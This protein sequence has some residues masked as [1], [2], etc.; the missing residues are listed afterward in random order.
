MHLKKLAVCACAGSLALAVACSKQQSQS[1]V[2]PS[3]TVNPGT[4]AAA[5]GSTLKVTAPTPVSPV[6]NAQPDGGLVLTATKS[7]GKFADIPLSYEFEVFN[8]SNQR[9]YTSGVTGGDGNGNNV[10]HS[11]SGSLEFDQPYTWRVRG[12]FQGAS[13][14]WSSSA[15]FRAP[16]GGYIRGAEIFDPLS[17]GRTVGTPVGPTQFVAGKGLQLMAH[18][19]RVTYVLPETVVEGEMSVMV[20]GID[21]GSPGDKSK[22]FSMQEGFGDPTTNDYRFT[23]EKR[24]RSYPV[25]GAVTW[26]M[27]TGNASDRGSINDGFRT[28]VAFSDERWYFWKASWRNGFAAVEVREDGPG[29]RVIYSSSEGTNGHPYRPTPHVVHLGQ[30]VGRGGPQDASI[31]GAIYKNLWVSSRPRPAFPGE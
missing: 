21:E 20:T 6:N 9:V 29:G 5:D 25:P 12:V 31:P 3:A 1:P 27:I 22:V 18:E 11:V 19:S 30:P 28:A 7:A 26:R 23:V 17:S 2:S 8:A 13:G 14:P 24:G 15:S 10:S 4:G 16:A